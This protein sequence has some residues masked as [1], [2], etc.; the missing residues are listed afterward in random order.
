[1]YRIDETPA[2]ASDVSPRAF[3]LRRWMG[4]R[5]AFGTIAG[6]CSA[7]DAEC[8]R[9]IRDKKAYVDIA[10]SWDEFCR[11]HLHV[12]RKKIDRQIG[13]L[14][15][16]GPAYFQIAQLTHI[17]PNEYRAIAPHLSPEGLRVDGGVIALL[18]ENTQQVSEAVAKLK[19]DLVPQDEAEAGDFAAVVRRCKLLI[20][21]MEAT[22]PALAKGQKDELGDQLLRIE[23]AAKKLGVVVF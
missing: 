4:R 21:A 10:A 22:A 6:R 17:T 18:P 2:P 5:D 15:E 13:L 8:L 19:R 3:D 11:L 9:L 23:V 20:A 14:D 1:M 12:S 16:F 7:A